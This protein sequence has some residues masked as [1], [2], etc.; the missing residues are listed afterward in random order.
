MQTPFSLD[1]FRE[2]HRLLQIACRGRVQRNVYASTWRK[3]GWLEVC[4]ASATAT[5]VPIVVKME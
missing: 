5:V 1:L 2:H 4:R 3:P